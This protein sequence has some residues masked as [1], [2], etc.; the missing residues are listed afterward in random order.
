M[1][2]KGRRPN[3]PDFSSKRQAPA[4]PASGGVPRP[5]GPATSAPPTRVIKPHSTSAKSGRRGQ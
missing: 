3:I 1:K 4:A 2:K 5:R